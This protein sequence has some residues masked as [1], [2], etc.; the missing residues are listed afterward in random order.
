[1]KK[2][3]KNSKKLVYKYY[4]RK[5]RKDINNLFFNMIYNYF[6]NFTGIFFYFCPKDRKVIIYKTIFKST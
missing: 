4:K 3:K 2:L 5:Y 1:M 6:L